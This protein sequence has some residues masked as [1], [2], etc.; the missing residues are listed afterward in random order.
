MK[1]LLSIF[2][3]LA[4]AVAAFAFTTYEVPTRNLPSA[5]KVT[6]AVPEGYS[7]YQSQRLPV[8]YL[9]NGHGGDNLSY[10][11]FLNLDS[12][13]T[14]NQMILVC[15]AGLNSWYWNSVMDS[16]LRMEAYITE[17]LVRWTDDNFLTIPDRNHRAITGLS[18]GG[19]G[20]LWLALRHPDLFGS[21]GSTSGGVDFTP[22][23]KSWNIADRLGPEKGNERRWREHTVT[24]L[25]DHSDPSQLNL[26]IDCGTED[27]FFDVNKKFDEQLTAKRIRHTFLT[28]PGI[29]NSEYWSKTIPVQLRFFGDCFRN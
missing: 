18:M 5:G 20:A 29:H 19:H 8:V 16:T 1:R 26:I 4:V 23:P 9:L 7:E 2:L 17:D 10:S 27:F 28:S 22:W 14:A 21:A 24:Y 3:Q 6:I 12:L 13:A 15:P 25:V 11:K